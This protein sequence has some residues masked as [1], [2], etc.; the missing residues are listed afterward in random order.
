MAKSK[1]ERGM[2]NVKVLIMENS[3]E[4][5]TRPIQ[6]RVNDLKLDRARKSTITRTVFWTLMEQVAYIVDATETNTAI[7]YRT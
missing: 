3:K 1:T 2:T 6:Q 7:K 5:V 4:M